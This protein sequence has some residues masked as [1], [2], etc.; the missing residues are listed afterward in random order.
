MTTSTPPWVANYQPGV[1]AE[2]EM[3]T[4]SLVAMLDPSPEDE[5]HR[6]SVDVLFRS[7]AEELGSGVLGVVLTGMGND[8]LDGARAIHRAGGRLLVEAESSCVV[9]GMPRAVAEEGLGAESV[10]LELMVRA[11]LERI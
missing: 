10:P 5:L 3:P 2:I 9:Y 6:P 1:P 4:E 11:I 8:G 7:A